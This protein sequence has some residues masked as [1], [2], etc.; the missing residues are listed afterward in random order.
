M[1]ARMLSEIVSGSL[2]SE[3]ISVRLAESVGGTSEF[4]ASSILD[5]EVPIHDSTSE[6]S[7]CG[8]SVHLVWLSEIVGRTRETSKLR[9]LTRARN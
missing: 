5:S 7:F 2:V 9:S 3:R 6:D 8:N 4:R 1:L